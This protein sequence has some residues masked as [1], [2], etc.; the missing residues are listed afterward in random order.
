MNEQQIATL[1][2]E[3]VLY[4]GIPYPQSKFLDGV[5]YRLYQDGHYRPFKFQGLVEPQLKKPVQSASVERH[6]HS[7][8]A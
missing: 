1:P 2:D 5:W 3:N 7:N 8:V 4:L 6:E